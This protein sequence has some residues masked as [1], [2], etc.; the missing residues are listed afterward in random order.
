MKQGW[1]T[2]VL[3]RYGSMTD[4][5]AQIPGKCQGAGDYIQYVD[6]QGNPVGGPVDTGQY[7]GSC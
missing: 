6:N 4:M 5:T 7:V 1:N 3:I 2:P